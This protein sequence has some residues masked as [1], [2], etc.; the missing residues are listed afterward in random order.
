MASQQR[1]RFII[2][3]EGALKVF[4]D[5]RTTSS[6]RN[7]AYADLPPSVR[8]E[9]FRH[10]DA[11]ILVFSSVEV[12]ARRLA[13]R[14]NPSAGSEDVKDQLARIQRNFGTSLNDNRNNLRCASEEHSFRVIEFENSET[15]DI[16]EAVN[17]LA[18]EILRLP[19]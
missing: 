12:A 10:A 9:F 2:V 14:E 11:V 4:N 15:R 8:K 5:M 16:A 1:K 3:G 17:G 18:E 7:L 19:G 6:S 13:L